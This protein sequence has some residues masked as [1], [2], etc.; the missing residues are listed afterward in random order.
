LTNREAREVEADL[1][2]HGVEGMAEAGLAGLPLQAEQTQPFLD[3]L[4]TVLDYF[5][6]RMAEDE[7]IGVADQVGLPIDL[8]A[9]DDFLFNEPNEG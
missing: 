7:V 3:P 6:I 4:L 1:P 2:V 8:A 9:V 5:P